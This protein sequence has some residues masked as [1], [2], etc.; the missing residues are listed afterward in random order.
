M[1]RDCGIPDD[2]SKEGWAFRPVGR[3]FAPVNQALVRDPFLFELKRTERCIRDIARVDADFRSPRNVMQPEYLMA[4]GLAAV[5]IVMWHSISLEQNA[6]FG[7]F[8]SMRL[9]QMIGLPVLFVP[10][11]TVT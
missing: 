10:I 7:F 6:G 4:L 8:A 9:Y 11:N 5:P 3:V 2:E 1:L